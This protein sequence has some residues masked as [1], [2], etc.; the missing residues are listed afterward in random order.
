MA[1][2]G[3]S[4]QGPGIEAS[5]PQDRPP[6]SRLPRTL[7]VVAGILV[8][9]AVAGFMVTR[10]PWWTNTAPREDAHRPEN[11]AEP[12]LSS[13]G[14][15]APLTAEALPP[16][17]EA[18]KAEALAVARRVVEEFPTSAEAMSLI[19]TLYFSLNEITEATQWWQKCLA[20][21]PQRADAYDGLASIAYTQGE[22]DKALELWHKAQEYSPDVPGVYMA[23]A[24]ALLQ[25]GK[26]QEVVVTLEKERRLSP[27]S[28]ECRLLLGQAYSQLKE[29][30]KAE[31]NYRKAVEIRPSDSRPHYGLGSVYARLGQSDRARECM[32]RFTESRDREEKAAAVFWRSADDR[33]SLILAQTHVDAGRF[34]AVR[35]RLKA[36]EEHW[37]RAAAID[38]KN[39]QCRRALADLYRL[40]G[41]LPEALAL[42]E[43]LRQVD[44]DNPA[45]HLGTGALLAS[46]RR[47]DAAEEAL[48][49]GLELAPHQPSGYHA[50][51]QFLLSRN[52][53]LPEAQAL[54]EKLVVLAPAAPNYRLLG[55]ACRRNGDLP[56][57]RAALRRALDLEAEKGRTRGASKASEQGP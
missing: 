56:G 22:H 34:Y 41:R 24:K 14:P 19:G 27:N 1:K 39:R 40:S 10:S 28:F 3:N 44:P 48:R 12:S 7:F 18:M 33:L 50:L 15:S 8:C 32:E 6:R 45:Y 54:A 53:K 16:T 5:P 13:S 20:Q 57:A 36:A 29:Y 35:Q 25:M 31:E 52:Q 55:E 38:P 21:D 51:A 26:A 37:Q 46:L 47:F 49:K 43:Q 23:P 17:P 4:A 11:R 42:F 9:G 2:I 30:A